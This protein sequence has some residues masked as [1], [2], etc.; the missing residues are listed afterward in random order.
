LAKREMLCPFSDK[1][2][3]NCS[4]YIGRHYFLCYKPSYRGHIKHTGRRVEKYSHYFLGANSKKNLNVPKLE[5]R[6]ALDPFT[7]AQ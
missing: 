7:K 4:L 1:L 6:E 2:C 3:K 5:Y